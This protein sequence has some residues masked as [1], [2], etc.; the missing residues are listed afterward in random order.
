VSDIGGYCPNSE[1]KSEFGGA[2]VTEIDC[3]EGND[4][5]FTWEVTVDAAVRGLGSKASLTYG[6]GG[7]LT[8]DCPD[9]SDGLEL[10]GRGRAEDWNPW[11]FG[12]P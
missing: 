5:G 2:T 6:V 7:S 4:K 1:G 3:E 11:D 9:K 8:G 12:V 10:E